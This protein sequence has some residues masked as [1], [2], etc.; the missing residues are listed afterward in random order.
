MTASGLA[1]LAILTGRAGGVSDVGDELVSLRT[2]LVSLYPNPFNPMTRVV[3][4]LEKTGSVEVGI[5][6]VRGQLVYTLAAGVM[7]R[8]R[9]D[10][11]WRGQDN[12]GRPVASGVYF[13][14]LLA[15]GDTQTRKLV[16]AR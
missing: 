16:L 13:C 6:D 8:G 14:R 3:F 5:Y 1:S 7:D 9:Y 2:R 4:E 10:L 11:T 12:A 15:G